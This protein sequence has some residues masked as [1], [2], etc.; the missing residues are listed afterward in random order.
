MLSLGLGMAVAN[1]VSPSNRF[2]RRFSLVFWTALT[3]VA[4][5]PVL[6]DAKLL[7]DAAG[8]SQTISGESAQGR[9][10]DGC[11][12]GDLACGFFPEGP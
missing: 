10:I 4:I 12:H 3:G 6:R 7:A 5:Y 2:M 9:K 1:F 11:R 8:P